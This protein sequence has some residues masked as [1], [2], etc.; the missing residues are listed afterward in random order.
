MALGVSEPKFHIGLI[1]F[2]ML[3]SPI[4]MITGIFMNLLSRKHEFEADEYAKQT[5]DGKE[6][7]NALLKLS[8]DHLSNLTP[9]PAY[10]F[11]HYS[12][13]PVLERVKRMG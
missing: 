4:S 10:V 11:V 7:A 12:H 5:F 3:Y 13:P 2:S 6:L 8:T 1:A 9:H